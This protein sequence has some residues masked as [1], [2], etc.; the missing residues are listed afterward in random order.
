MDEGKSEVME[1]GRGDDV[2]ILILGMGWTSTFLV[3]LLEER[4]VSWKG[5]TRD[6]RG[7]AGRFCYGEF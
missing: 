4:G 6:G 5:T 7:L 3:P 2:D 1:D